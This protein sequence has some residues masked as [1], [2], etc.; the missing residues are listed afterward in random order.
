MLTSP[1]ISS[2][3]EKE[4]VLTDDDVMKALEKRTEDSKMEME[5]LEAIEEMRCVLALSA[6]CFDMMLQCSTSFSPINN[7][8]VIAVTFESCCFVKD[9]WWRY[10]FKVTSVF[11]S[12][13][14]RSIAARAERLGAETLIGELEDKKLTWKEKQKVRSQINNMDI[15]GFPT[16]KKDDRI[17]RYILDKYRYLNSLF[18]TVGKPYIWCVQHLVISFFFYTV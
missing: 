8:L 15:K 7:N 18:R 1:L 13:E 11:T 2:E 14:H 4:K 16:S 10:S 5:N 12:D 6:I 17:P 3:L 9:L